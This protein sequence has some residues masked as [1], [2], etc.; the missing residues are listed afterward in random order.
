MRHNQPTHNNQP[1]F[2]QGALEAVIRFYEHQRSYL[3]RPALEVLPLWAEY[4][5]IQEL[6]ADYPHLS[7]LTCFDQV[8]SLTVC[9]ET[10]TGSYV[11]NTSTLSAVTRPAKQRHL[12]LVTDHFEL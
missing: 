5:C 7:G 4:D 2:T 12:R 9:C 8:A 1:Q 10:T 6:H 3:D 11:V